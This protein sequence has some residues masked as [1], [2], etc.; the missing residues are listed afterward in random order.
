M[1]AEAG[2]KQTENFGRLEYSF[3]KL[4]RECGIEMSECSLIEENGRAHFLT[5]RFDREN[6]HKIHMQTLCGMAHYDFRLRRGYSYEQAF[7]VMRRLRL[8]YSQAR[9]MFRRMVFNVGK[10]SG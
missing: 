2:F 4:V 6:G 10:E 5:K 3:Y 7:I 8:P 1:T 9:E